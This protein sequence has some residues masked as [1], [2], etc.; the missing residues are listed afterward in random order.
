MKAE[1]T[2]LDALRQLIERSEDDGYRWTH[3]YRYPTPDPQ[4]IA[5]AERTAENA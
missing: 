3:V 1:L 4:A 5:R 2:R